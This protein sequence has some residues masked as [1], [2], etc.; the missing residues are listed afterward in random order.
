MRQLYLTAFICLAACC[1]CASAQLDSNSKTDDVLNALHDSGTN[2][3]SFSATVKLNEF[4]NGTGAETTR[5]GKVW[6]QIKPNGEPVM[7]IAFDH[8][9]VGDKKLIPDKIEYLLD[10]GWVTDRTDATK[11]ESRIQ[12]VPKGQKVDLFQLGKSPFPMPIGQD[13]AEIQRQ[14]DVTKAAPANDDPPGS[15]HLLLKPKADAP[16][17]NRFSSVDIWTD[18]K[19]RMP[20]RIKTVDPK[21]AKE[22]TADLTDL[23]VNPDL[24]KEDVTLPDLPGDWRTSD[25]PLAR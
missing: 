5:F 23:L 9:Q 8:K 7:H 17:A 1:G 19:T 16:M 10:D 14:F 21:Q 6:F 11:T 24:K 15:V 13:P 22:R 18:I 25:T 20:V 4:D 12:L 2:I 3:K